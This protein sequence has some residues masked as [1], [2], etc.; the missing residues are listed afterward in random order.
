MSSVAVGFPGVLLKQSEVT[1]GYLF[2]FHNDV[3]G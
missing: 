1:I 3:F 2:I